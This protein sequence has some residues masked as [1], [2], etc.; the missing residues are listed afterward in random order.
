MPLP[1]FGLRLGGDPLGAVFRSRRS[2]PATPSR[3]PSPPTGDDHYGLVADGAAVEDLG[4]LARAVT[5]EVTALT[6]ACAH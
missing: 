4:L 3:S 1:G 2:P 5:E 6:V